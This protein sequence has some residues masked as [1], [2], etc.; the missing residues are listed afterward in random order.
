MSIISYRCP[1]LEWL[2][3]EF[4][5][6]C[7]LSNSKIEENSNL[8][9]VHRF[10]RLEM[11][12]VRHIHDVGLTHQHESKHSILGIIAEYCPILT[13]LTVIGFNIR[14]KD[15]LALIIGASA[16]PFD[17]VQWT[18]DLVLENLKVPAEYLSPLCFKLHNLRLPL[19][20][21]TRFPCNPSFSNS[22]AAFAYRHLPA[23]RYSNLSV[24]TIKT[25]QLLYSNRAHKNASHQKTEVQKAFEEHCK[26]TGIIQDGARRILS[27]DIYIVKLCN[28]YYSFLQVNI[29][30]AAGLLQFNSLDSVPIKEADTLR[31]VGYMC[32]HL[33]HFIFAGEMYPIRSDR[34]AH[35]WNPQYKNLAPG[36]LQSILSVWPK[37]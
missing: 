29:N 6:S 18:E 9:V 25:I 33:D 31:A 27:G 21:I 10:N 20:C 26:S 3:I 5:H 11:L 12:C 37:V 19:C 16:I 2:V 22:T 28:R 1:K 8:K 30:H 4:H 32:P 23:L 36:E 14:K 24:P 35:L 13:H 17:D 7:N 34:N 15:V